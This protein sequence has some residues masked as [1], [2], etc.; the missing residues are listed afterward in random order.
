MEV[1]SSDSENEESVPRK[2]LVDDVSNAPQET[3][4]RRL[5]KSDV[6]DFRNAWQ[7]IK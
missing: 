3:A 7:K 2:P 4:G 6:L 5:R 1:E